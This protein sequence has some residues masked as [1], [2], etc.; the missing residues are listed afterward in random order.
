MSDQTPT[1]ARISALLL[2]PESIYHTVILSAHASRRGPLRPVVCRVER[3]AA[4]GN[5]VEPIW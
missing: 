5:H 3:Y 4:L 2:S 1:L